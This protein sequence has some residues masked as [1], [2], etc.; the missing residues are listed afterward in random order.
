MTTARNIFVVDA[1]RG[2]GLPVL[3]PGAGWHV[4][5][6]SRLPEMSARTAKDSLWVVLEA[7]AF[8]A[9]LP[10]I[11]RRRQGRPSPLGT[12]L[13]LRHVRS[14]GLAALSALFGHVIAQ[15]TGAYKFL[16]QEELLGALGSEHPD[17]LFIAASFDPQ[18]R[19]LA[20]IRGNGAPVVFL[21]DRLPP[22]GTGTRPDPKRLG[23]ADYGHTLVLGDYEAAADAIL[24]EEDPAFRRRL[25]A[26]RRQTE[27]TFGAS[28]RRLRKQRGLRQGDFP[29]LTSKEIA[30]IERGEVTKPRASTLRILGKHLGVQ[31]EMIGT[32]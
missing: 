11:L 16:P 10:Q 27:K 13:L 32:Y 2:K 31:S 8:R 1:P 7:S 29:P 28:L 12:L 15:G 22:S 3:P 23:L 4:S 18:T 9:L 5:A 17:E 14:E 26:R 30:R 24:Y 20:L 21:L 6:R 25:H 19:L